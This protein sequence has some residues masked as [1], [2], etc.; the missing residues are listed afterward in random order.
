MVGRPSTD[1]RSALGPVERLGCL[2]EFGVDPG[3]DHRQGG[4]FRSLLLE[5]DDLLPFFGRAFCVDLS[6][7]F[8][9]MTGK[10]S[11]K[12]RVEPQAIVGIRRKLARAQSQL[13]HIQKEM[14]AYPDEI[15]A[16]FSQALRAFTGSTVRSSR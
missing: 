14:D 8:S 5:G 15:A 10:G 3:K 16:A 13:D 2:V 11:G 1:R 6:V 12:H 9:T 7:G 4:T